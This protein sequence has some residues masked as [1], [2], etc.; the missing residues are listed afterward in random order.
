[1]SK[2]IRPLTSLRMIAALLVFIHH[3]GGIPYETIVGN[4]FQAI[5][6]EGHIG[7]TVFF[8]LSGFLITLRYYADIENKRFSVKDYLIKRAARI[9]PLYYTILILVL[10]FNNLPAFT[11]ERVVNW[12]LTQGF[13]HN[14]KFSGIPTAWSLT[15]EECFYFL[16]PLIY[17]S[18][19][20]YA[21][22]EGK[23]R[24]CRIG[25]LL[26]LWVGVFYGSGLVLVWFSNATG[27]AQPAGFML[28]DYHMLS[29][30]IFGR[31]FDF[32]IGIGFAL[33]YLRNP[34]DKI[35]NPLLPTGLSVLGIIGI[36]GFQ[37]LLNQA[38]GLRTGWL[39][40]YPIAVGAGVLAFSL[41][42]PKSL[43]S[44]V[45]D[46]DVFVYMGRISYALYLLQYTF[47]SEELEMLLN[48]THPL[49]TWIFYIGLNVVSVG[50]YEFVEKPGRSLVIY[51]AHKV[52]IKNTFFTPMIKPTQSEQI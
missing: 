8:V 13:F 50:F 34:W 2:E 46:Q 16:A 5:Q 32:A 25:G 15:V 18:L 28:T 7:V 9:Y 19:L 39:Y 44:R 51:L 52:Q 12:T 3:F 30:T 20:K 31:I 42:S 11:L 14:L 41:T 26:M 4:V 47:I 27:L 33:L 43:V 36:V 40:I 45:L 1:M 38:G 48:M 10:L 17:L 6:V 29:F 49:H 23:L 21:Y 24:W 35:H 37:Y 22:S